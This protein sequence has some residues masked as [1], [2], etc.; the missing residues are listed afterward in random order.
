LRLGLFICSK[1]ANDLTY[2]ERKCRQV[3]EL[4]ED[5]RVDKHFGNKVLKT[6][7]M[8]LGGTHVGPLVAH[9]DIKNVIE[10]GSTLD[11]FLNMRQSYEP[12]LFQTVFEV[13]QKADTDRQIIN[14]HESIRRETREK[15]KVRK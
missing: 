5:D 10:Q 12:G 11:D 7:F 2:R 13:C 1:C 9:T 3:A 4:I 14:A 15:D 8:K 6:P